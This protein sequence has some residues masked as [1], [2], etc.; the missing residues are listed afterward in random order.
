MTSNRPTLIEKLEKAWAGD[1]ETLISLYAEDCTFEDKALGLIH[2]GHDGITEVFAYTF[3]IMPNFNVRYGNHIVSEDRAATEWTFK[4]S[5]Q[6]ELE[7]TRYE[8]TPVTIQGISFME[9]SNGKIT[10]NSD[11]W[12]F[13]SLLDQLRG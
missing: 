11:Y 4:G 2:H 3:S 12:N 9:F 13:T 6:G 10:R 7:G 1:L 5:F 8:G